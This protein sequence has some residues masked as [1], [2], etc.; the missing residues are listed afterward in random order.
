MIL[1]PV[2]DGSLEVFAKL[3]W[4]ITFPLCSSGF[5]FMARPTF[6]GFAATDGRL[7]F[8]VMG[9]IRPPTLCLEPE[10]KPRW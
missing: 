8:K 4:G 5:S 3:C 1:K 10:N 6:A 9:L 7:S 2:D